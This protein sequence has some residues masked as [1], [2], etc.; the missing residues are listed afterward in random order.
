MTSALSRIKYSVK[1]FLRYSKYRINK[2]PVFIVGFQRSGTTMIL[3]VMGKCP[4]I[5]AIH[6]GDGIIMEDK[7]YRL[8]SDDGLRK[9]IIR[10]PEPIIIFKPLNDSQ[11]IDRLLKIHPA[12]KAIWMYRD[13]RDS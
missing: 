9:T 6:E 1:A 12:S 11:N 10:T 13:F 5:H 3:N 4:K 8:I 2:T 7:Y